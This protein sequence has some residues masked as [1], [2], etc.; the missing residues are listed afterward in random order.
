MPTITGTSAGESLGGTSGDDQIYGLGG[1]DV[2]NG[3]AAG[4]TPDTTADVCAAAGDTTAAATLSASIILIT[5]SPLVYLRLR[6]VSRLPR[7]V[8]RWRACLVN[9][10]WMACRW[11]SRSRP[12]PT[13]M[14]L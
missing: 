3:G 11:G 6:K 10:G 14:R 4:D 12:L 13:L 5:T 7:R 8:K 2:L 9:R 1:D